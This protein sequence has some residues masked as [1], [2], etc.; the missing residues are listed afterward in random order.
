[1]NRLIMMIIVALIVP[2]VLFSQINWTKHTIVYDFTGAHSVYAIDLDGDD[3]VDVLGAALSADDIT[4]WENDGNENF[5]RH[6]IADNFDGANSVY[7]I[8]LDGDDDVDVL[9]AAAG[10]DDITWWE[11]DGNENFT[12]DTIA[13][14]FDGACSVYAIDLDGDSDIDVLGA[15]MNAND[16]AWWESDLAG[17]EED[18]LYSTR[19][20]LPLL[21]VQPNPFTKK[22]EIRYRIPDNGYQ[23]TDN[24]VVDLD[25]YD[26]S[27]RLVRQF[28]HKTIGLSDYITWDGKDNAG[29]R[30][31]GGIYFL[32]LVV[33]PVREAGNYSTTEKLLLIK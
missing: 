16:I 31:C 10:G 19:D 25:I 28:D 17:I 8:D 27:G 5:A 13:D 18:A 30:V 21:Q 24:S 20:G 9:G 32:R 4:W 12:E 3:D 11:N 2:A 22:T 14:D 33:T 26:A 15:G 29:E 1:M 6:T 23:I 7:A